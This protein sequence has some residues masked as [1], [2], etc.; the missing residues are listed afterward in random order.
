[1]LS[2]LGVIQRTTVLF[3]LEIAE[4]RIGRDQREYE[5]A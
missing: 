2:S 1:M 5:R 3:F 4:F